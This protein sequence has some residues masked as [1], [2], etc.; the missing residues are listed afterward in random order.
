MFRD[1]HDRL[2]RPDY[3]WGPPMRRKW[4]SSG[5]GRSEIFDEVMME[6]VLRTVLK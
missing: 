2:Q 1:S 6:E 5:L 4:G 3:K